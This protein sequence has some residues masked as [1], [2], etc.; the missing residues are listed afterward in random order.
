MLDQHQSKIRLEKDHKLRASAKIKIGG[1]I[2]KMILIT[3][4][5]MR[6]NNLSTMNIITNQVIIG[7]YVTAS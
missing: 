4:K 3:I 2:S 7:A 1:Y 6:I 5:I